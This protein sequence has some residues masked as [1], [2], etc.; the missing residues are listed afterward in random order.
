[1]IRLLTCNLIGEKQNVLTIYIMFLLRNYVNINKH[2]PIHTQLDES[3][4]ILDI[5]AW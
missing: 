5:Y 3:L 1:M 2:K 4:F